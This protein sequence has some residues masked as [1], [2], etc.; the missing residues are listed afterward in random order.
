MNDAWIEA[1]EVM[2]EDALVELL[3]VRERLD[4][5]PPDD[6]NRPTFE[7]RAADLERRMNAAER[8]LR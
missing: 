4:C 7:L 2:A 6:L 5:L 1:A 3:E 8:V